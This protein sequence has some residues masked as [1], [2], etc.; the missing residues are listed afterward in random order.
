[1]TDFTGGSLTIGYEGI[2]SP[3]EENIFSADIDALWDYGD[4]VAS[5]G[6]FRELLATVS[7]RASGDEVR[8]QIA[9]SLGLQRRFDEALQEL[10]KV[11]DDSV[12]VRV[13]KA[14]EWG[15]VLNSSGRPAE[16]VPWFETALRESEGVPELEFYHVDAAHMLGIAA[17][18]EDRLNW[19]LRAID[20]ARSASDDRARGWLGSLLNNTGW[21]LHDLGR[22]EEAHALFVEALEYRRNHGTPTTIRIAQWCVGRSLRSLGRFDEA[23]AIQTAL[24]NA[25]DE[26]GYAHEEMGELLLLLDRADEAKPYFAVAHERLAKDSWLSANEPDRIARLATLSRERSFRD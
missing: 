2:N 23:F 9:R 11:N 16:A 14:L 20:L 6:R 22:F 4:P 1:M 10:E 26:E 3:V 7:S 24:V 17:A 18:I 19:N 5:E 15:R 12:T 8:T 25:G 13:R 21:S